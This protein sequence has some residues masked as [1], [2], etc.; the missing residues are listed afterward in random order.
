M[1]KSTVSQTLKTIAPVLWVGSISLAGTLVA[2]AAEGPGAAGVPHVIQRDCGPVGISA[3]RPDDFLGVLDNLVAPREDDGGTDV[4]QQD[5]AQ[6][7]QGPVEVEC[8]D[9][10]I[11]AKG[12]VTYDADVIG[13]EPAAIWLVTATD[14]ALEIGVYD[15]SDRLVIAQGESDSLLVSWV[16]KADV[17]YQVRVRN[18]RDV[19]TAFRICIN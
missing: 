3:R 17:H 2:R 4:G 19:D 14:Q 10:V 9:Q 18:L 11:E 5:L 12:T 8:A 6:A 7:E 13:E 15:Q 1:K 16:P